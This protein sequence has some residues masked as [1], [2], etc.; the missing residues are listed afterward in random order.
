MPTSCIS[1]EHPMFTNRLPNSQ[2]TRHSVSQAFTLQQDD[3]TLR[4][5]QELDTAVH[6]GHSKILRKLPT[7]LCP[8]NSVEAALCLF[9]MPGSKPTLATVGVK[10]ILSKS[11]VGRSWPTA[12]IQ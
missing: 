6:W 9:R 2:P 4:L 3:R 12:T 5:N 11:A 10:I 8:T 1:E 7:Q